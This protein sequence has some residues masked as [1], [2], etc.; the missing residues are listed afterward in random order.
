MKK[1]KT[2]KGMG[3]MGINLN[4]IGVLIRPTGRFECI[5][6]EPDAAGDLKADLRERLGGPISVVRTADDYF[7]VYATHAWEEGRTPNPGAEF[8]SF[9]PIWGDCIVLPKT[10]DAFPGFTFAEAYRTATLMGCRWASYKDNIEQ[11]R[12]RGGRYVR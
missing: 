2:E 7:F 1:S 3:K 11:M 12:E 9:Q 10:K 5:P 4:R 6:I 8:Y